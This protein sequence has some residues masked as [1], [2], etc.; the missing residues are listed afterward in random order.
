MMV[1]PARGERV[2]KS[3]LC[4]HPMVEARGYEGIKRNHE[5]LLHNPSKAGFVLR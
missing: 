2:E 3:I 5:D 1:T 4:S